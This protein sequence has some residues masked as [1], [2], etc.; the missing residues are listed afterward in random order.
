MKKRFLALFLVLL[1]VLSLSACAVQSTQQNAYEGMEP[2]E[3]AEA[4]AEATK[5]NTS[6]S[7]IIRVPFGYL[8]DWLYNFSRNYGVALLLFSLIVKLVLF[9]LSVKSKKSMLKMSR[10]APLT[11]ALEAKYGDDK[12]KYQMAVQQ[13]YKEE[14]VSMGGGCLWSFIPLLIL[15]P[16]Y[17]VIREPL[18]YM[19]HNSRS[20]SAAIVAY[21]QARGVDLGTNSYYAQ[22]MATSHLHEYAAE[23]KE[24]AVTAAANLREIDFGFLGINLAAIPSFKFWTWENPNWAQIGLFLIPLISGAIQMLSMLV[25]QKMNNK[26]AT[27][28]DGEQD[29]EA[30]KA[31]NQTNTTMML[32]MPLMSLWIGYSMPAAI[33][34]YWIAQA[35]FGGIQD[36][37]LTVHYRKVYDAEDAERQA[38]AALRRAEEEEKERQRAL[39]REQNPDGI[40]DNVSK[41]KL[42][43]QEKEAAAAAAREYEAKKAP[44]QENGDAQKPLSGDPNRPYARGRA[45]QADRYTKKAGAAEENKE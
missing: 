21:I 9:P 45:Y 28:A 42:K 35:L 37:F 15:L 30:A 27:N 29:D 22:L 20:V 39:R 40:T 11:K 23:L 3:A 18:T 12:Q 14:G 34:I 32:M 38:R 8:L 25:S 4:A 41:K 44:A 26:V 36:Y 5:D 16:L 24:L 31:A 1:L 7:D 43:Q 17:Y 33:S 10:L 6:I 19:L 13:L 2:A